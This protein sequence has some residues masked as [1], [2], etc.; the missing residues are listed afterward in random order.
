[1]NDAWTTEDQV[2]GWVLTAGRRRPGFT[3]PEVGELLGV[4][5]E[6][7]EAVLAT[8]QRDGSIAWHESMGSFS[9]T[10]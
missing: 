6:T 3:A 8:M 2:R 4:G 7:V 10:P 9:V 5:L 1:M